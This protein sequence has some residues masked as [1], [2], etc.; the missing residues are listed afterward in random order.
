MLY[1]YKKYITCYIISL[2]MGYKCTNI[3]MY[4]T[5]SGKIKPKIDQTNRNNK[6]GHSK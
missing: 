3:S 5:T 4:Q 2:I 1:Y 6:Y